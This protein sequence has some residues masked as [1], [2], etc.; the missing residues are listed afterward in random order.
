[1]NYTHKQLLE[2]IRTRAGKPLMVRELMRLLRLKATD[3]HDLKHTLSELVQNGD[4]IKTRGNRYGL[5]EKMDL[6][7]GLFQAHP[8]GYGFVIPEKKGQPDVYI[9]ARGRLDAMNGDKVVARV[10]PPVGR[11]KTEGKREGVIIRILER[12]H[13]RIVGTYELPETKTSPFGFIT[14]SN[15][16]ITQDVLISRENAGAAKPGDIVSA[17]IIAYPLRG[18]PP[19]G[20][21]VKVIGQPG[22]PGIDSELIIEQYELPVQFSPATL[23]EAEAVPQQVTASMLKGRRDL[24]K[25]PTVTIDGETARDFDDAV[26]I[27]KIK[28]GFRLWVHI[29][30]VAHYVKEDSNLNEEAYARGTSV[31]LPDRAIPMLPEALSNGIC[32]LNPNVDRLTLTCEMDISPSG[33]ILKYDIYESVINSNE[34]MTYTAVREILVDKN[35]L[36]R[37]R[38]AALLAEFELMAELMEVLRTKRSKRGSIDFDLPE[39]QIVLDLQGRMT[40]IIRAERNMAH[41]IIEEFM[42]AANETV[43]GHIEDKESPFL[44][45]IHEEPAE[46]KL[47]DLIEFLATLGISLPAVKKLK[48]LHLQKALAK[49][50]GTPEETLIN[51]VLLRT[52][53]QARY[54]AENVGHFGLAA[55]TYTHFTSPIRRFPDL[56]VHRILKADL[57]DKLKDAAYVAHLAETLPEAAAHCSLRERTAMEAERDVVAMLKLEFM[58][59]KLGEVYDGI[60]TGVMQFGLFVQLREFFDEGLVHVST[61]TDDYYHYIEKLHCLRGERRKCVYRIGDAIRVRVDRVDPVRKRI[62]FSLATD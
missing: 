52:M 54:S 35:P 14:P 18:R 31:Y 33:D 25:H 6:E 36:Q 10:S 29:A 45:R 49:A 44:Y 19:E 51:T 23:R 11:K 39:P 3:R 12:A 16:R 53:K 8:S 55:D 34:R 46:E 48:P 20:R 61:L 60:V 22:Q 50:K 30:D 1:M 56:I 62:D 59:D 57:R 40:E 43:A 5:P 27:E 24:R 28:A 9:S 26:S 13:T 38:Y 42:L 17:E 32:S 2:A 15:H 37:K 4:I 21:I 41:Q 47:A 58:K 7:T